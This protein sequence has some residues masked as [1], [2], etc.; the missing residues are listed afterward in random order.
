[1]SLHT[2]SGMTAHH[3][4]RFNFRSDFESVAAEAVRLNVV[5]ETVLFY[6]DRYGDEVASV[7]IKRLASCMPA[8]EFQ[9]HRW[10][11]DKRIRRISQ[12]AN[13]AA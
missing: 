8:Y 6:R 3:L 1:M 10:I 11:L 12:V 13:A 2:G 7:I 4:D 9:I 5:P